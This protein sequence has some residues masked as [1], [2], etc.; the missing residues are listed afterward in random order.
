MVS[1]TGFGTV[2]T[3]SGERTVSG[4]FIQLKTNYGGAFET[5]TAARYDQYSLSGGGV[6]TQGNRVSPKV[7]VGLTT[8]PG[9]TPYF[10]YAEGYRAGRADRLDGWGFDYRSSFA[11]RDATPHPEC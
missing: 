2:F 11:Y 3:P 8:I 10:I 1:T 5:I 7:T 9:F 4:S 6:G